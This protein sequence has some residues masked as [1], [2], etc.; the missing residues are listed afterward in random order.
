MGFER[1]RVLGDPPLVVKGAI[2]PYQKSNVMHF[3]VETMIIM[4]YDG[5]ITSIDMP[6]SILLDVLGSVVVEENYMDTLRATCTYE[7]GQKIHLNVQ[8]FEKRMGNENSLDVPVIKYSSKD[9]APALNKSIRLRTP[10]YYRTLESSSSG[11]GDPLEG[12]RVT[13]ELSS[14]SQM[15]MTASTGESF[16]FDCT[17]ARKTDSCFKT[18]M[19]CTSIFYENR[20]LP[21][22]V[23]AGTFGEAYTH[24][25]VFLSSKELA[26]HIVTHFAFVVSDSMLKNEESTN[27]EPTNEELTANSSAWIVHGPVNYEVSNESIP[28]TISSLFTKPDKEVYRIQDEYRFWVGFSNTPVQADEATIALSVDSLE[29]DL[30]ELPFN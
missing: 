12:C 14:G 6:C 20:L 4:E 11:L 26:R 13:H 28:P 19:F 17:A 23:T 24:G 8:L 9:H 1:G 18:F 10:N 3:Q 27:K 21:Q 5:S 25:S 15:V 7:S 22:N 2:L 29:P 30:V 16:L